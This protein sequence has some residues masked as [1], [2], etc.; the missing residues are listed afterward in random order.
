M[1]L[2]AVCLLVPNS[3]TRDL[4]NI[5]QKEESSFHILHWISHDFEISK[6]PL[7][8]M[9]FTFAF[10]INGIEIVARCSWLQVAIGFGDSTECA[11][12]SVLAVLR[13]FGLNHRPVK[14]LRTRWLGIRYIFDFGF[15]SLKVALALHTPV[16]WHIVIFLKS[17][18]HELDLSGTNI[19]PFFS[20]GGVK[21][22]Y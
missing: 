2:S 15:A 10:I 18:N 13:L 9:V 8:G 20:S 21:C 14:R 17:L 16:F 4:F 5:L 7:F 11:P 19:Q 1:S 22:R 3:L 6:M 12:S